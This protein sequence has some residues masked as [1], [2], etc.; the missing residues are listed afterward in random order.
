MPE[1]SLYTCIRPIAIK[2]QCLRLLARLTRGRQAGGRQAGRQAGS[3]LFK[4][5]YNCFIFAQMVTT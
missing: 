2:T 5:I 1:T 4:P 3:S